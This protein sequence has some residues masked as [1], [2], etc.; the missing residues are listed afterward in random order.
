MITADNGLCGLKRI[1]LKQ[2]VDDAMNKLDCESIVQF[3]MVYEWFCD[4]NLTQPK[5]YTMQSK[6]VCM[7]PLF[8]VQRP[9]CVPEVDRQ[10]CQRDCCIRQVG[11]LS[12]LLLQQRW[13]LIWVKVIFLLVLLIV[14]GLQVSWLLYS[15]EV[16]NNVLYSVDSLTILTILLH[17][18][19]HTYVLYG[20]LMNSGT[21]FMFESTPMYPNA[22]W[23]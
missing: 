15:V 19:G 10:V 7:D 9:Y 23:Y 5:E 3:I 21:T 1:P 8:A 16:L 2:I 18:I 11:M 12:M 14:V 20:T 6:D 17:Q 22:G 13:H 4:P